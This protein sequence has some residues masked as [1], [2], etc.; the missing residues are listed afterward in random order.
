MQAFNIRLTPAHQPTF[1]LS[2]VKKEYG[3]DT[4]QDLINLERGDTAT[5]PKT[6]KNRQIYVHPQ[7]LQVIAVE[8]LI[9][10]EV[11]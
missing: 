5:Q 3:G 7:T 2:C 11:F 8:G 1:S 6:Q 10:T 4:H 9:F